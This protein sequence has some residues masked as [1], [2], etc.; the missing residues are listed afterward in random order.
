MSDAEE[1]LVGIDGSAHGRAAVAWA[2]AEARSRSCGVL[3]VHVGSVCRSLMAHA[4]GPVV[5]VAPDASPA[6]QPLTRVIVAIGDAV[7]AAERAPAKAAPAEARRAQQQ[8]G[9]AGAIAY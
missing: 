3:L 7:T 8:P 4:H 6:I 1:I 9:T 5:A 2:M